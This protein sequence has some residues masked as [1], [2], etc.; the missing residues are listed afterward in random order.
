MIPTL[1]DIQNNQ[2]VNTI[3]NVYNAMTDNQGLD[4]DLQNRS[5]Q[6]NQPMFGGNLSLTGNIGDNP[7]ASLMFSKAI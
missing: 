5:L 7:G 6:Y 1:E 4:I 2:T 3:G